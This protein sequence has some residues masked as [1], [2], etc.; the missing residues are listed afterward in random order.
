MDEQHTD[1]APVL[2]IELYSQAQPPVGVPFHV[3]GANG[4]RSTD[5][6]QRRAYG[7]TPE[8][9]FALVLKAVDGGLNAS[10]EG[11]TLVVVCDH[12]PLARRRSCY[13]S[14]CGT[15]HWII[16]ERYLVPALLE[17]LIV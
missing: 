6:F 5:T 7:G 14:G 17:G 13:D 4:K 1:T 9:S 12:C 16:N 8:S 2:E 11:F 15:G 3:V 10:P